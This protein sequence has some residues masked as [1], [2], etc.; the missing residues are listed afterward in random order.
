MDTATI[1][2]TVDKN[3]NN[4]PS[5]LQGRLRSHIALTGACAALV[6][7]TAHAETHFEP[8][9]G[10]D[11]TWTDNVDLTSQD[12]PK[13]DELIGQLRPG[14]TFVHDGRNLQAFLDYQLQA[15]YFNNESDHQVFHQGELGVQYAIVPDWFFLDVGGSRSQTVIDPRQPINAGNM[16]QTGNLADS[17]S[18]QISPIVRHRFRLFELEASYTRGFLNYSQADTVDQTPT[19]SLDFDD[20]KNES[21]SFSL[22]SADPDA[23][24]TWDTTYHHDRVEYDIAL[25]FEYDQAYAELGFLIGRGFRLIAQ[26][27]LES[28]PIEHRTDGGLDETSYKGGFEW[29]EGERNVI[30]ALMGHRFFGKTYEGLWRYTGRVL[31]SEVSYIET[32]T[33]QTQERV[34]RGITAPTD[35]PPGL[36]NQFSR[37]TSDVYLSKA[38]EGRIGLRGRVTGIFLQGNWER[39]DYLFLGD[40]QD[41]YAGATLLLTRRLGPRVTLEAT[42]GYTDTEL[43]EGGAYAD[44]SYAVSLVRLIGTKTQ[45]TLTGNRIERTGATQPYTANWVLLGIEVNFAGTDRAGGRRGFT[46]ARPATR[47]NTLPTIPQR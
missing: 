25:P 13:R 30:R 47:A 4:R 2:M 38:L 3:E 21:A 36:D 37:T 6:F 16:F 39:R 8:R 27:G 28:D 9:I 10:F 35:F 42:L 18:G 23:R 29:R 5:R 33:T 22:R 19:S 43:R 45:L 7:G 12:Q 34:V 24:V 15:I 44:R 32:P 40:I 20:S 26:G 41:K 14:I 1:R 31:E 46:G 11:V 17:T